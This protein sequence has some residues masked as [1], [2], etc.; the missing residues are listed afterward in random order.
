MSRPASTPRGRPVQWT[1][2]RVIA[3]IKAFVAR[4]GRVPSYTD[5]QHQVEGLPTRV[6][7]CRL[8]GGWWEDA[9]RAA[10]YTPVAHKPRFGNKGGT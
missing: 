3:A 4:T 6:T 8:W 5:F 7:V 1:Q 10:G 9:V 2:A